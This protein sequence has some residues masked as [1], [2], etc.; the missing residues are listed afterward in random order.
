MDKD[1]KVIDFPDEIQ[2][3]L[4]KADSFSEFC[5][6]LRVIYNLIVSENKNEEAVREFSNLDLKAVSNIEIDEIMNSLKIFNPYLRNFLKDSREAIKN[7]DLDELKNI[8]QRRE[9]FLKGINRSKT[10][11]PGEYDVNEW[12]AGKRLDYRF[13]IARVIVADIYRSEG[14]DI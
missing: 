9:V 6:A 10:V 8:I 11:H 2:N 4:I 1:L 12:F 7:E 14:V 13:S 5:F 3:N